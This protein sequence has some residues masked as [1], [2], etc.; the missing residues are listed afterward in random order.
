MGF[1]FPTFPYCDIGS[2]SSPYLVV[3]GE[4]VFK[5]PSRVQPNSRINS[6]FS[7]AQFF[8]D[9]QTDSRWYMMIPD[10]FMTIHDNS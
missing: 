10:D 1:F 7:W 8:M 2:D 5:S 9:I 4:S 3:Q 6:G